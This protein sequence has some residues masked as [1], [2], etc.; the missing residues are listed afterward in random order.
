M[1]LNLIQ[2]LDLTPEEE[3]KEEVGGDPQNSMYSP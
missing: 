1:H 3:E 2:D